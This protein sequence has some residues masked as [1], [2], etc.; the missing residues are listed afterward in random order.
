MLRFRIPAVELGSSTVGK[1]ILDFWRQHSLA[2]VAVAFGFA[3][4]VVSV[5]PATK[6]AI[7]WFSE[8]LSELQPSFGALFSPEVVKEIGLALLIAGL[9][10][11]T[12]E[13][14]RVRSFSNE[15]AKEV[16]EKL[17]ALE[18]AATDAIMRGPLPR[19]YYEHV[20]RL[21]LLRHFLRQNWIV[22]LEFHWTTSDVRVLLDQ[23]YRMSNLSGTTETY[24]IEHFEQHD[25]DDDA[26]I[27]YVRGTVRG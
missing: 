24:K 3:L 26:V 13:R 19:Q 16:S 20:K 17:Q 12:I 15:L 14:L 1:H 6:P 8:W 11:V 25:M 21:M 2:L 5:N 4:I 27:R 22:Q 9:A 10:T 18:Y 7:D 23:R